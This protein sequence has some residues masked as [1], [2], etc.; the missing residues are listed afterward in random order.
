M[1]CTYPFCI[2]I[3][4]GHYLLHLLFHLW[5]SHLHWQVAWAIFPVYPNTNDHW[6]AYCHLN[7]Q[8][9]QWHRLW[10]HSAST[11]FVLPCHWS[12]SQFSTGSTFSAITLRRVSCRMLLAE[13][14]TSGIPPGEKAAKFYINASI[15]CKMHL[16]FIWLMNMFVL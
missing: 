10:H 11:F 16:R 13:L 6:Q 9:G 3:K 5:G 14:H 4:V 1:V 12:I 7:T 15:N 8:D 2:N